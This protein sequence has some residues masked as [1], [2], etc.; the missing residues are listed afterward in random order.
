VIALLLN[1]VWQSS[2]CAGGAGLIAL[3]LCRNG[4]GVRFW[5]WFA[6]SVKFLVPFAAL[7][8][9]SAYLLTPVVP[10]VAAPAIA[11]IEPLVEPLA[12]PFSAPEIVLVTARW[13]AEPA[14]RPAPPAHR[15]PSPKSSLDLGSALLALWAAGFLLLVLRWL[16]RWSRV[17][18]LLG[19]AQKAQIDAPVAVKFSASRLEPGLV[20]ILNPVILLPQGI[21][22]QL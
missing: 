19:G 14:M 4:A 2:L 8:A 13:S 12:K 3:A 9:L 15:A 20:G 18:V 21:E 7:T 11:R 22:K 17:R 6:A 16:V 10:P 1:H 5:L